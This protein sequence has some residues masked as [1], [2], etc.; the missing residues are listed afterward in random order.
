MRVTTFS[1]TFPA[2]HP[3]KGEPTQFVE[4]VL[5]SLI[6][7][8]QISMSKAVEIGRQLNLEGFQ[9]INELR[10]LDLRP[11]HHTIRAGHRWKA[12]D[13]FSPRFWT[14]KPYAS[15]QAE[16]APGIEIIKVWPFEVHA[17]GLFSIDGRLVTSIAEWNAIAN[18]DGLNFVDF[19][20]WLLLPAKK[21]AK[22]FDGQIICWNPDI[23]Y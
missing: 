11:K 13:W 17:D 1:R 16:F 20:D 14:G 21:K 5:L 2:T 4:K 10:Q 9:S 18:N 22:P 6:E 7:V 8:G 19:D 12:G 23:N 3:R 15:K